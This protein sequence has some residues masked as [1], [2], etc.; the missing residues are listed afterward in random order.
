ML[1]RFFCLLALLLSSFTGTAAFADNADE[2][3][4]HRY[5]YVAAPGVRNYLEY[6]GHG[7]LVFDIDNGHKFVRRIPTGGLDANGKPLNVKGVCASA[8][9]GRIYIS[10]LQHLLCLDLV[11]EQLLWEKRYD[12]GCD[13]MS[14]T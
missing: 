12:G 2:K 4:E 10:T 5:L 3:Q 9:T 13:R 6:G 1:I 8:K 7:L 11:T 14:I